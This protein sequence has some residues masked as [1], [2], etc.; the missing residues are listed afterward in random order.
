MNLLSLVTIKTSLIPNSD[1][2]LIS[3]YI[4]TTESNI[5]DMRIKEITSQLKSC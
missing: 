3:L 1:Q 2:H 5:K 4:I